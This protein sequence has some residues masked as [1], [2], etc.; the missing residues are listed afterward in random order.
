M[1]ERTSVY[2]PA[3]ASSVCLRT[4]KD[5]YIFARPMIQTSRPD[6][7]SCPEA[8]RLEV[9]PAQ[10]LFGRATVA[11]PTPAPGIAVV[12]LASHRYQALMGHRR[13]CK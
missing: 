3:T 11:L 4:Q 10:G 5:M 13:K 8:T 2:S 1:R 7:D 12:G 6:V 9:A